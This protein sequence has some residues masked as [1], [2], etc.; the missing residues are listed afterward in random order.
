M[1][2]KQAIKKYPNGMIYYHDFDGWAFYKR[3][4]KDNEWENEEIYGKLEV[5][6]DEDW[7]HEIGYAPGIVVQ[8]CD[9]LGIKVDSI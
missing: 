6:T 4:V 9:A 2:L 7:Q 8:L 3:V 5:N 1:T